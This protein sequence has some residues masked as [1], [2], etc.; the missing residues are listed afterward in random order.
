MTAS[1]RLLDGEDR[2]A[3][4]CPAILAR[5]RRS[6]V[7]TAEHARS[8]A[9]RRPRTRLVELPAG[10]AVHASAPGGFASAVREFLDTL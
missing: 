1:Q 3:G 5:G 2:V 10:H 6:T 9:A 8:M 7:L 4:G